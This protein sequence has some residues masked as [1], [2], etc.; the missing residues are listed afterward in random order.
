MT[1]L[2]AQAG[3]YVHWASG[4]MNACKWARIAYIYVPKQRWVK[5]KGREI[6]ITDIIH[7]LL[8]SDHQFTPFYLSSTLSILSQ[9]LPQIHH[10]MLSSSPRRSLHPS[11]LLR[12]T[13]PPI[14]FYY[15]QIPSPRQTSHTFSRAGQFL[16]NAGYQSPLREL[17]KS[18]GSQRRLFHL[19]TSEFNATRHIGDGFISRNFHSTRPNKGVPVLA[20]ILGGLKVNHLRFQF[21]KVL[22][23]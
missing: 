5:L 1:W 4:R 3:E 15:Y 16:L 11:A 17:S 22:K 20:V 12:F 7:L 9:N 19:N 14:K 18:L 10:A 8:D 2:V 13:Y 21:I 6:D 23:N